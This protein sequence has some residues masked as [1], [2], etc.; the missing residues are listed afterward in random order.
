[1]KKADVPPLVQDF[2]TLAEKYKLKIVTTM[3]QEIAL[4]IFS[5]KKT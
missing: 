2:K 4:D 1:M 5:S 3:E